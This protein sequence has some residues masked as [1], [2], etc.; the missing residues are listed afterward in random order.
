[1]TTR[2]EI[3]TELA[4]ELGVP[5]S[6]RFINILDAMFTRDEARICRE[7]FNPATRQEL[8]DKLD[9]SEKEL[10]PMLDSLVDR[11]MLTR[12]KTQYA[13]HTS[14]L[15][16]HHECVAD[17]APHQGPNAIP[18]KVK[19]LWN[20]FFRNE[21]SYMFME[22][23]DRMVKSTG[24]NLPIS[25]AIEA[26]ERSTNLD[27][28]DIMP[29]ENFRQRI[30]NAK[31]R[32]IAPCGCRVVWGICDY[33]LMTCFACFDRPRGDYYLNQPGRLLKEV[34]LAEAVDI[35]LEAE[36]AGLVHWGD[37]YC[38]DCCCENLFPITRS[39]RFD[40]MTPNR[41]LAVVDEDKCKG[42]QD[43]IERCKFDA[44]EM[45]PNTHTKKLKA[46]ISAEKCKGCGLCVI[47]CPQN[48]IHLEIV[49]PPEYLKPSPPPNSHQSDKPVHV[50]PVWGH[51]DLK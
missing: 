24:K 28:D 12:G 4:T 19:E 27:P 16:F 3:Y 33:P 35:A 15:A 20:D 45:V 5:N 6:D 26:L 48:A 9:I 50:I 11:G 10:S 14:L 18:Q 22:H 23:T 7:L 29:E 17:T 21:W 46:T 51:Y 37:C 36:D 32:I 25:P 43:C 41:F 34:T 40:L 2:S 8:A 31:R 44:I 47:K 1:M 49:R 42:C 30:E 38:C 13:F 39:G